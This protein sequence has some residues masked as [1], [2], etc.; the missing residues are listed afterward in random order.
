MTPK[1]IH[2]LKY[3]N[4]ELPLSNNYAAER[5]L[6]LDCITCAMSAHRIGIPEQ[7]KQC[8]RYKS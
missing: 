7:C 2:Q 5:T 3:S 6:P 8:I 4:K 1:Q